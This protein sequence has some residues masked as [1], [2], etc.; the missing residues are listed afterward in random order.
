MEGLARLVT[1]SLIRH[2]IETTLDHRRLQWSKWFRCESSFSVLLVPGKPGLFALGEEVI[3]PGELPSTGGKR[4]LALF[5]ITETDDLGMA[6]GRLFLPGSPERERL[7]NGHCF[8]RYAVIEDAAQRHTANV[9]FQQWLASSAEAAS[10]VGSEFGMK[11]APFMGNA[12]QPVESSSEVRSE[13]DPPT[14][15]PAGF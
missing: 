8:A 2:G 3:A 4:M 10:G 11:S 7:A 12:S 15:I 9:A 14:P 6:L 5:R 13:I 1:E